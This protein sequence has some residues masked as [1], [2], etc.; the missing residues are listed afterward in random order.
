MTRNFGQNTERS[1]GCTRADPTVEDAFASTNSARSTCNHA[2]VNVSRK[3]GANPSNVIGRL[4][5]VEE[6]Y[7]IFLLPMIWRQADSTASLNNENAGSN[8]FSSS[9]GFVAATAKTKLSTL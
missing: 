9:S 2:V 4:T 6:V 7:D 5:I 3:R 1:A 8:S